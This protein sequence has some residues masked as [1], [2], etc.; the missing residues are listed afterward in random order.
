MHS[1]YALFCHQSKVFNGGCKAGLL[2]ASDTCMAGHA[3]AQVKMFRLKDALLATVTLA[4]YK[5]LKLRG[6]PKKVEAYL[7]NLDMQDATFVLQQCCFVSHD[8]CVAFGKHIS[9]QRNE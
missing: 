1:I 7:Q 9:L 2:Y 5:D 8:L 6:F 4:A 3:Y